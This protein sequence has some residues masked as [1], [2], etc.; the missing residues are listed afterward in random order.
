VA[1]RWLAQTLLDSVK[2]RGLI[3]TADETFA[4]ADLYQL[5]DEE[6]RGYI[7]PLLRE[8]HEEFLHVRHDQALVASQ[9]EY[10]LPARCAAEAL[11]MV[12]LDADGSGVFTPLARVEPERAN[13]RTSE[14]S[15]GVVCYYLED[16]AVVLVPAPAAGVSGSLRFVYLNRPNLPVV[17]TAAAEVT[18]IDTGTR[19]VT[20]RLADQS[21]ATVPATFTSSETY[22]LIKGTPGFRSLGV[23]LAATVAS[24]V[25]TFTATLPSSL[26]VGD[27]VAL[28]GQSPVVQLPAE[29]HPLLSQRVAF[30]VLDAISPRES[31][32]AELTLEKMELKF[33]SLF[34][35]RTEAQPRY[36]H[37]FHAVGWKR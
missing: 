13:R 5:L 28:A 29:M 17:G 9:S 26:A 12:C 36:A 11:K 33:R 3:P 10:P 4:A 23:D 35:N 37:N 21:S 15:G 8:V 18:A 6:T 1:N 22:D 30:V 7:L 24:N 27:F 25:L 34:E 20:C 32:K 31:A 2:R 16:D 19:A 14:L